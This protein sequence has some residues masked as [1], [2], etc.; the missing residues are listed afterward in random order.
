MDKQTSD[1]KLF[2]LI[3]GTTPIKCS[4]KAGV[5]QKDKAKKTILARLNFRFLKS[6]LNL[7]NLNKGLYIVAALLTLFFFYILIGGLRLINADLIFSSG[8][9]IPAISKF[10]ALEE[11]RFLSRQEYLSQISK[12][13]MF[14]PLEQKASAQEEGSQNIAELVKDLKLVGIIWSSNPEVMIEN[15]K[16]KRTYLLKKEDTFGSPPY[17]IKNILHNAV[18]LEIPISE[19][20]RDYELK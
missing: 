10:I 5:E 12:R 2:K 18:V 6:R 14:L 9:T 7:Y 13:N 8:E 16:E 17:K 4:L 19:G 3:E 11:S 1:E 15:I 20:T